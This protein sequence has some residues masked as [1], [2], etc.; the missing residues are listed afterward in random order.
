MRLPSQRNGIL[1]PGEGD[2][3]CPE[4]PR[5]F[6]VSLLFPLAACCP[7]GLGL[8]M[9]EG[10]PQPWGPPWLQPWQEDGGVGHG[11]AAEGTEGT[12]LPELQGL[13]KAHFLMQKA[14][15][16]HKTLKSGSLQ[17]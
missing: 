2:K 16:S 9:A 3:S 5:S 13:E 7:V 1:R 4:P 8:S 17:R 10:D 15:H 12:L 6:P 14:S 11:G